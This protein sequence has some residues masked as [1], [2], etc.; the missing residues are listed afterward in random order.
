MEGEIMRRA[1]ALA[2][3]PEHKE[4][5]K[6]NSRHSKYAKQAANV[7][8]RRASLKQR[9][10]AIPTNSTSSKVQGVASSSHASGT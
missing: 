10:L 1:K 3:L 4:F 6:K 2:K 9:E 8:A 7:R 5:T